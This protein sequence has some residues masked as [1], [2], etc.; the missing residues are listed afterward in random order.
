MNTTFETAE[1]TRSANQKFEEYL[2][3]IFRDVIKA[4]SLYL[5]QSPRFRKNMI[6]GFLLNV[7][8]L[9]K[10]LNLDSHVKALIL[11]TAQDTAP[12]FVAIAHDK[13]G[14]PRLAPM[15]FA[16]D[17]PRGEMEIKMHKNSFDKLKDFAQIHDF[18]VD[19]GPRRNSVTG[20]AIFYEGRSKRNRPI[21]IRSSKQNLPQESFIFIFPTDKIFDYDMQ[22][23]I[24][25]RINFGQDYLNYAVSKYKEYQQICHLDSSDTG[26]LS[27]FAGCLLTWKPKLN[28]KIRL[29][30]YGKE[31]IDKFRGL[32]YQIPKVFNGK[33]I[34]IC[35]A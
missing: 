30:D 9:I 11:G 26:I 27:F 18:D 14:V 29:I 33:G 22:F 10:T 13:H 20:T 31:P 21:R 8:I 35:Q 1:A 5:M 17:A 34:V 6:V 32:L 15:V 2:A 4:K 7:F 16:E 23:P 3:N 19:F 12:L 25:K 28:I 24:D